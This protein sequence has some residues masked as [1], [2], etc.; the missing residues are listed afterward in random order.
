MTDLFGP[1]GLFCNNLSGFEYRPQQERL[2]QAVLGLLK[3]RSG[4]ILAAEAPPGVGKTFAL[5]APAITWARATGNTVLVLT[6]S[7]TLQEQLI[8]K[9]LPTLSEVLGLDV[10][11]GLLKGRG[12]YA[13]MRKA[14]ELGDEGLLSFNDKGEASGV[15]LEWL[16]LTEEGDLSEVPLPPGHPAVER[17]AGSFRGCLGARCPY[18]DRCFV[19]RALRN[20]SRWTVVVANYHLYFSYAFG[21]GGAFPVPARLVLCDEA[22][23]MPEA[24]SSV[25]AVS[26]RMDDWIRH[27]RRVPSPGLS[28]LGA[29]TVGYDQQ[30]TLDDVKSLNRAVKLFFERLDSSGIKNGLFIDPPA[31]LVREGLDV[32]DLAAPVVATGRR[33]SSY[34]D[35]LGPS[36]EEMARD[37][38]EYLA[39][40]QVL[41]EM[42]Q[43]FRWCLDVSDYPDWTY[44]KEDG[45]LASAPSRCGDILPRAFEGDDPPYMVAVSATMAVDGR[46]DYWSRE[47]GL[48]PD[49][50]LLLDSPFPLSEQ[51][52]LLVV[53]LGIAVTD[54]KYDD[55]VCRVV[56]KLCKENGGASLVL[57]SSTR[58]L[59]RVGGYLRR[60]DGDGYN[61]LIQGDLPKV[62]LLRRFREDESSVLVG[63]V[64]FREGVDVPGDSLTQ[65][66]IDRIPFPHP[67]DPIQR[68]RR[69]LEGPSSFVKSVLPNAKMHLRQAV[70]RLIRSYGD[71]GRVAVLDGRLLSRRN[72]RVLDSLPEVPIRKT[73]VVDRAVDP[74]GG[75]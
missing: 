39:W 19:Q 6:S 41:D 42:G 48:E 69:D 21:K 32:L 30:K 56:R 36:G 18:R 54:E 5:L 44:W 65:V 11:F 40:V 15:I 62:E 29:K 28:E 20:A 71:K 26:T 24:A 10:P 8:N 37:G 7:I 13:C 4:R 55:R 9:D 23:R 25:S 22:H 59:K 17:I 74:T 45:A 2:S 1:D 14:S 34:L 60:C 75:V 66:I 47:T 73:R 58:L 51:M 27:L 31:E 63:T 64:S 35:D 16:A 46:F 68:A 43:A 50:S 53:D 61:V 57:L 12:N 38:A 3:G 33:F 49:D 67:D 52:E 70:G 72:W